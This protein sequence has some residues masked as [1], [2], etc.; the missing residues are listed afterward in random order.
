[1]IA[2]RPHDVRPQVEGTVAIAERSNATSWFVAQVVSGPSFRWSTCPSFVHVSEQHVGRAIELKRGPAGKQ[3]SI[4]VACSSVN[5]KKG[6]PV[7]RG[8]ANRP[9]PTDVKSVHVDSCPDWTSVHVKCPKE[10]VRSTNGR[11][12]CLGLSRGFP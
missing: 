4:Q 8:K 11:L 10:P 12:C 2:V 6:S 1:M 9:S 7:K 3:P 5:I